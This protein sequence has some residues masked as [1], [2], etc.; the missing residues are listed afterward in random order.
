ME[1]LVVA[2]VLLVGALLLALVL[3]RRRPDE[4]VRTSW[5]VP[6]W[7]DRADFDSPTAPWLVAVFTSATCRSCHALRPRR[8]LSGSSPSASHTRR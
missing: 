8:R 2:A 6:D 7:V 5:A 1:R 4:P 3:R